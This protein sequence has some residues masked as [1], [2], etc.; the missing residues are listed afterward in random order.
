MSIYCL[1]F[2]LKFIFKFNK[3]E[4]HLSLGF[5]LA[6]LLKPYS[7]PNFGWKEII[8]S[9]YSSEAKDLA[10]ILLKNKKITLC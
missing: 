5:D 9:F 3:N 1:E 8:D 10:I 6:F 7:M 2:K 4:K